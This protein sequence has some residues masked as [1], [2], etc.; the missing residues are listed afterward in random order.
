MLDRQARQV[1]AAAIAARTEAEDRLDDLRG[2]GRRRLGVLAELQGVGVVDTR[3]V[4]LHEMDLSALANRI[5]G[6]RETLATAIRREEECA[7]ALA[8]ARREVGIVDRLRERAL[9]RHRT[10]TQREESAELDEHVARR[11][12]VERRARREVLR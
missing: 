7:E 11:H 5:D 10:E 4:L 6:A 12:A 2:M 1:L 9:D 3:A 8:E